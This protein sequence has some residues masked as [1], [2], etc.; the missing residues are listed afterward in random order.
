VPDFD[1]DEEESEPRK[2]KGCMGCVVM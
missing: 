2:K 1:K